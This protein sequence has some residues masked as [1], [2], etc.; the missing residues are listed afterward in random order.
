MNKKFVLQRYGM[1]FFLS[2]AHLL[3]IN[4]IWFLFIAVGVSSCF[5]LKIRSYHTVIKKYQSC[6]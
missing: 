1:N 6:I 4:R 5:F 3:F 2:R